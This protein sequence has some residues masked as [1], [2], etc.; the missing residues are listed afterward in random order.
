MMIDEPLPEN[1]EEN[2]MNQTS[3]KT[4][5]FDRK[6]Q[7]LKKR[8]KALR[9]ERVEFGEAE[10]MSLEGVVLDSPQDKFKTL[11]GILLLTNYRI[12]FNPQSG[13]ERT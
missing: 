11:K 1:S 5:V 3:R 13:A 7:P 9:P 10:V 2:I 6:A 8:I 12:Y 4:S